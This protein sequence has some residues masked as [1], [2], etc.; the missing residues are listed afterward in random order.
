MCILFK[1]NAI[2]CLFL[3]N[4]WELF[5]GMQRDIK[6]GSAVFCIKYGTYPGGKGARAPLI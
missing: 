3:K 6:A 4:V 2:L 5:V 1:K